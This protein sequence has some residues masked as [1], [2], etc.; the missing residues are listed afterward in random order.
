MIITV[1]RKDDNGN[2]Y[3]DQETKKTEQEILE[4][5]ENN[6]HRINKDYFIV[7][8]ADFKKAQEFMVQ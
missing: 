1:Y 2:F 4:Y 5:L 3:T 6:I 7:L 8:S